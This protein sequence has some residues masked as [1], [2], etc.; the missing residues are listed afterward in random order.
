MSNSPPSDDQKKEVVEEENGR[1]DRQHALHMDPQKVQELIEEDEELKHSVCVTLVNK[2]FSFFFPAAIRNWVS[3]WVSCIGGLLILLLLLAGFLYLFFVYFA[4]CDYQ[5]I[6]TSEEP[7]NMVYCEERLL[8]QQL[9]LGIDVSGGWSTEDEYNSRTGGP[10][11]LNFKAYQANRE[12]FDNTTELMLNASDNFVFD[13][14]NKP[15]FDILQE[16]FFLQAP[17]PGI[18]TDTGTALGDAVLQSNIQLQTVFNNYEITGFTLVDMEEDLIKNFNKFGSARVGSGWDKL[19]STKPCEQAYAEDMDDFSFDDHWICRSSA[20]FNQDK[21]AEHW[22]QALRVKSLAYSFFPV[23]MQHLYPGSNYSESYR[24]EQEPLHVQWDFAQLFG[25]DY[26][27]NAGQD[28]CKALINESKVLGPGGPDAWQDEPYYSISDFVEILNKQRP[29]IPSALYDKQ[30]AERTV[31]INSLEQFGLF[32]AKDFIYRP[33]G[34][35]EPIND[36]NSII[37]ATGKSVE[38][39]V[40]PQISLA[41]PSVDETQILGE[42]YYICESCEERERYLELT[43]NNVENIAGIC[44]KSAYIYLH[45]YAYTFD[46]NLTADGQQLQAADFSIQDNYVTTIL[47]RLDG[48]VDDYS[49]FTHNFKNKDALYYYNGLLQEIEELHCDASQWQFDAGIKFDV[50]FTLT[51]G[52]YSC[53][54]E[55][56]PDLLER[57]G[58]TQANLSLLY[59]LVLLAVVTI[60]ICCMLPMARSKSKEKRSKFADMIVSS[61]S[62]LNDAV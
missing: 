20:E 61:I 5:K 41:T 38:Y 16:A 18:E 17:L 12:H 48:K 53:E 4:A 40:V 50:P 60:F 45:L 11:Q 39:I 15:F 52:I 8:A 1:I 23:L 32:V 62:E 6:E 46:T 59:L 21:T 27:N 31:Y 22:V 37:Q 30:I 3:S 34:Y 29:L 49:Y 57:L 47:Y 13:M 51:T 42:T 9:V 14:A 33:E 26:C 28:Q 54:V 36:I 44:K 19:Q 24:G 58:N 2:L 25:Y 10:W 56:C 35:E 7:D 43:N 55:Y